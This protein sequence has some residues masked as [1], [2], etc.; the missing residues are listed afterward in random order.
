MG[1]WITSILRHGRSCMRLPKACRLRA[2]DRVRVWQGVRLGSVAL[3]VVAIVVQAA[4]LVG[5]DRF[6]PTRF[7]AFFTIQSN[8]IGAATLAWLA[9]RGQGSRSRALESLRGA[10]AV[11][12]TITFFVVIFLLSGVD[13]GLQLGWVDVV[14]HKLFPVVVVVDCLIDPPH[15]RL[16]RRDALL[17]LAF[18]LA[19]IA[20]TLVRGAADGW[21]PYPFLDPANRGYGQ[22]AVT[23]VAIAIGFVVVALAMVAVTNRVRRMAGGPSLAPSATPPS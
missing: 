10:A 2:V 14:L 15:H 17:W 8:L 11:Y 22:V 23:T 1:S 18:P 16:Q 20:A 13:V 5:E 3:V 9:L 4:V 12:L 6:D 21:Y 7:F 19:W